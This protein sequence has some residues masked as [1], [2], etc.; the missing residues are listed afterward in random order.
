MDRENQREEKGKGKQRKEEEGATMKELMA[1]ISAFRRCD[2]GLWAR[3]QSA[4]KA[5][6]A[7]RKLLG[8]GLIVK[9]EAVRNGEE[10]SVEEDPR[11]DRT[12]EILRRER[13]IALYE[14]SFD[15]WGGPRSR[16]PMEGSSSSYYYPVSLP[17]ASY[18]PREGMLANRPSLQ[19]AVAPADL[20]PP[21]GTYS[22]YSCPLP[23][24]TAVP[25][26][27]VPIGEMECLDA[28]LEQYGIVPSG[29]YL[30]PLPEFQYPSADAGPA[31]S[32]LGSDPLPTAPEHRHS[33]S[34]P[35]T[36]TRSGE[37][38]APLTVCPR[39]VFPVEI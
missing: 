4:L 19:G 37:N 20:F 27:G 38:E 31:P 8:A 29:D 24:G 6:S 34:F 35:E 28:L 5:S 13:E 9:I 2:R 17:P 10:Y 11:V 18:F 21:E 16:G 36:T 1:Y 23:E 12:R 26:D 30:G 33:F 3:Y 14:R 39:D 25:Y 32:N 7:R 22:T 15:P